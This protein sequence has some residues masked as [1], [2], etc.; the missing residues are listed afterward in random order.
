[1]ATSLP[2]GLLN[3]LNVSVSNAPAPDKSK[4]FQDGFQSL[5]DIGV[6]N[7]AESQISK[8]KPASKRDDGRDI[9]AAYV[10]APKEVIAEIRP[11]EDTVDEID[12]YVRNDAAD[13][14]KPADS[15]SD[16]AKPEDVSQLRD[17]RT[18]NAVKQP[19]AK[20]VLAGDDSAASQQAGSADNDAANIPALERLAAAIA[21]FLAGDIN[22]QRALGDLKGGVGNLAEKLEGLSPD[23]LRRLQALLENIQQALQGQEKI[24]GSDKAGIASAFGQIIAALNRPVSAEE[25]GK[26]IENILS[27]LQTFSNLL[28]TQSTLSVDDA[29]ALKLAA[30]ND[31]AKT[32]SPYK[33]T[34]FG[35][36]AGIAKAN[37][38]GEVAATMQNA[39]KADGVANV[40]T[41]AQAAAKSEATFSGSG[42][43][44]TG[45]GQKDGSA[46]AF[47][48]NRATSQSGASQANGTQFSKM[49]Q[50][51]SQP[52]LDQVIFHVK[53]AVDSGSSKIH[54]QLN[55]AE[56]GKLDIKLEVDAEGKTGITVTADNKNTLDL[57]QRDSRGLERALADAG[58]KADSGSLSFNLRSDGQDRNQH[59]QSQAA[60][61][62][63]Q[64]MPE[65]EPLALDLLTRSYVVN[66]AEGLDIKI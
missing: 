57:L 49:L 29:N 56:L 28:D 54:I 8:E 17:S 66:L 31:N 24:P 44:D 65:E 12:V 33:S 9:V 46:L 21:E 20:Q 52:V 5:L 47:G 30:D 39:P 55:P 1:M 48:L 27:K 36:Q 11:A 41:N 60:L 58:L 7:G 4:N 10:D 64:A 26:N 35:G 16:E 22:G 23:L 25:K 18:D 61:N 6:D 50:Q 42:F 3:A 13:K 32:D 38:S 51:T 19:A 43:S 40:V 59:E 37:D 53:S 34:P 14:V 45:G 2:V 63:K 62:Y 15:T